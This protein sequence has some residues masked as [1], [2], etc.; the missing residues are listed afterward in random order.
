MQSLSDLLDE[1]NI[2]GDRGIFVINGSSS[3]HTTRK[4]LEQSAPITIN[5]LLDTPAMRLD[6]GAYKIL[7][8]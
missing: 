5:A 2:H 1:D 6:V 7:K 8:F 3:M 4:F